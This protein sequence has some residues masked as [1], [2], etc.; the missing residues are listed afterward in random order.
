MVR[1]ETSMGDIFLE[2]NAEKAPQTVA[3]FLSYVKA[4]HYDGTVF[5]RVGL[6]RKGKN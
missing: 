3:N 2:L 1:L 5:H 4:G 6:E